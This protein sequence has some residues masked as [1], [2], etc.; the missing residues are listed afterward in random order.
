MI[1]WH[2]GNPNA[3]TS[4][5]KIVGSDPFLGLVLSPLDGQLHDAVELTSPD[6]YRFPTQKRYP[7]PA[8][9]IFFKY[10]NEAFMPDGVFLVHASDNTGGQEVYEIVIKNGVRVFGAAA[11]TTIPP[12]F[13]L[14]RGQE[15]NPDGTG[16]ADVMVSMV[17]E[18][19]KNRGTMAP[20]GRV[21]GEASTSSDITGAW[22]IPVAPSDLLTPKTTYALT[23]RHYS[24][25]NEI[26]GALFVPNQADVTVGDLIKYSTIKAAEIPAPTSEALNVP[27]GYAKMIGTVVDVAGRPMGSEPVW[28]G[29]G[30]PQGP[31]VAVPNVIP[32]APAA[33]L[34]APESSISVLTTADKVITISAY[35]GQ[36][37]VTAALGAGSA[38][39]TV[40]DGFGQTLPASSFTY[41]QAT[42][43]LDFSSPFTGTVKYRIPSD[44]KFAV[45][46]PSGASY[47]VQV[48]ANGIRIPFTIFGGIDE[49][50]IGKISFMAQL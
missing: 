40:A 33:R 3:T 18:P 26:D 14:V 1:L 41:T 25:G 43:Q 46:L 8:N 12:P 15:F 48:G 20:W 22:E 13:C 5:F 17:L 7:A 31:L 36:S 45:A 50:D 44:G 10:L 23:R 6:S 30:N 28:V 35:P 38:L 47:W 42:G 21:S 24:F 4:Y 37:I 49:F 29:T 16:V 32:A 2:R 19:K 34:F 11:P 27:V 39:L 9:D